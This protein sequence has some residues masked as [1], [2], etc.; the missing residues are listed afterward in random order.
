MTGNETKFS[1]LIGQELFYMPYEVKIRARNTYGA[2]PNSTL[3]KFYSAE[4]SKL[5]FNLY[6]IN[7]ANQELQSIA[8]CSCLAKLVFH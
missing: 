6:F 1:R 7:F 2:S 4:D 8:R 5:T 3:T